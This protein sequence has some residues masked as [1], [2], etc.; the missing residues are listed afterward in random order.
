[1]GADSNTSWCIDDK[2][3]EFLKTHKTA[4]QAELLSVGFAR[5]T[6]SDTL[7][8]SGSY[9]GR[10]LNFNY[11]E[12]RDGVYGQHLCDRFDNL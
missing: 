5:S 3:I 10:Y 11:K 6:F 1:M 9:N 4:T 7:S 8:L 12:E 2:V